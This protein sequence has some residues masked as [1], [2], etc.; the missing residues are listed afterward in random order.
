MRHFGAAVLTLGLAVS[1]GATELSANDVQVFRIGTGEPG[2]TYYP[3]GTA[4]A[5][6]ISNPK[7]E[8]DCTPEP[9]C[10]VPGLA[11]T[12]QASSGSVANIEA[13]TT[14]AV[15]SAFAQADIAYWAYNG[16]EIFAET[17]RA[18]TLRAMASLY[19]EAIHLVV[20]QDSEIETVGDLRGKRVALDDT[21]SGTLVDARMVLD[22]YDL[23]ETEFEAVYITATQAIEEIKKET[24]DAFFLVA[25]APT[26]AIHE[27]ALNTAIRLV[28]ISG[29]EADAVVERNPFLKPHRIAA[30]TYHEVPETK[31]LSLAAQWITH[32]DQDPDL[33]Y[34]ILA[35]TWS[36]APEMARKRGL[37]Q[38]GSLQLSKAL[39][40][41]SVPLHPGA[42]RYYQDRGLLN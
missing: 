37:R 18:G 16:Q 19:V 40:G 35:A 13:L 42:R 17:G 12:V 33:I 38:S 39:K 8:V 5:E 21:G 34:R 36:L 3:T 30:G 31:T 23:N 14:G 9:S 6:A 10:G 27:F 41:L 2:G 32:V 22:A 25:G 7:R 11:V 28:P 1:V 15:E 4:I 20:P 29:P 26:P 24:L